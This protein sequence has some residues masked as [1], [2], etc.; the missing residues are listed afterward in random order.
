MHALKARRI[1]RRLSQRGL[2]AR[3]GVSFRTVQLLE[4]GRHDWRLSTLEKLCRALGLPPRGI[5]RS[6]ERSLVRE[7]DSVIDV[8]ERIC[9]EG[10]ASWSVFLFNFVDEFRRNPRPG[11]VADPPDPG[12]PDRLRCLIASTVESLCD[13]AGMEPPVWCRGVGRLREPWFVAGIE[14]LKASA[15]VH[16]P[17]PFRQRNV[18]VL[19]NFLDRA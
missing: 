13:E 15:L 6:I 19:D 5:E 1:A 12:L 16:S 3:A 2:A 17:A 4:S 10:E 11:L 7:E 9:L 18:F 8:S 14:S